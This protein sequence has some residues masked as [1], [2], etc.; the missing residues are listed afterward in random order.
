MSDVNWTWLCE[1][2]IRSDCSA[3]RRVVEQLL[4]QLQA[5]DWDPQEIFGVRLAMDE[6]MT[7]AIRH[8]NCR[9]ENKQI[10]VCFR[11]SPER[12]YIEIADEGE[13]FDPQGVPDCTHPENLDRP[14]G[15]GIMLMRCFMSKVEYNE[16]GNA[17]VME[18]VRCGQSR[19]R[20]S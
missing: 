7:N 1:H 2:V 20:A 6:A 18:K 9:D 10:R 16:R 17:V 19:E 5:H 12:L 8:G 15:R 3:G 13:G 14:C 4:E 11:L